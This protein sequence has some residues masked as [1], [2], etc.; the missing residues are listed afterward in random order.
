MP[1]V[2]PAR[3]RAFLA[4]LGGWDALVSSMR[5][6]PD[7]SFDPENPWSKR[8]LP[9]SVDHATWKELVP[10]AALLFV[11]ATPLLLLA[12]FVA[13]FAAIA[14]APAAGALAR[15]KLLNDRMLPALFMTPAGGAVAALRALH[16]MAA[17]TLRG[18]CVAWGCAQAGGMLLTAL[19][20]ILGGGLAML[21]TGA[22]Y[23]FL[24]RAFQS[25]WLAGCWLRLSNRAL[26]DGEWKTA[27][28]ALAVSAE[29]AT[30]ALRLIVYLVVLFILAA[31]LG[32]VGI[33]AAIMAISWDGG[34]V[35]RNRMDAARFLWMDAEYS[36]FENDFREAAERLSA[37]ADS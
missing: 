28:G 22:L 14:M 23:V 21:V 34:R 29:S 25:A 4:R 5:I 31:R 33:I 8:L 11:F 7:E 32:E 19:G 13:P 36:F 26:A 10:V 6:T 30:R 9:P 24:I 35:A 15:R 1:S 2:F 17:R 37:S 20:F 12:P 16:G 3:V 18:F 27:S